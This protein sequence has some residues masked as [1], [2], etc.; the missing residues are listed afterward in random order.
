[1]HLQAGERLY[2]PIDNWFR[3]G[4]AQQTTSKNIGS[5][6]SALSGCDPHPGLSI[7]CSHHKSPL[8]LPEAAA[9]AKYWAAL[10][11]GSGWTKSVK[12]H[13][14]LRYHP[15]SSCL[16]TAMYNKLYQSSK[17]FSYDHRAVRTESKVLGRGAAC[18]CII[19][20]AKWLPHAAAYLAQLHEFSRT[21]SHTRPPFAWQTPFS[22]GHAALRCHLMTKQ[23]SCLCEQRDI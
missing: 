1:M 5:V 9:G 17:F 6:L 16:E 21:W 3:A 13:S 12:A 14:S 7:V 15:S 4:G 2:T 18:Y 19:K 20:S 10:S 22:P 11:S 8:L 23:L